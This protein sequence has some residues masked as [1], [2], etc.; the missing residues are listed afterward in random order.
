VYRCISDFKKGYQPITDVVKDE[1]GDLVTESHSI[2]DRWRNHFSQLL[3]V[4]E[5]NDV[6]QTEIH[7]AEPLVPEPSAESIIVPFYKKGDK[8]DC[9][10]YPGISLLSTMY[11]TVSDILLSR[12]TPYAEE[13]V[14]Y[15][16]C[17]F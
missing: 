13:V 6:V 5:I 7:I 14:E 8:T 10:N 2:L 12:L 17:R 16:Q 15:H 9:S 11:K 1:K 3:N 4:H